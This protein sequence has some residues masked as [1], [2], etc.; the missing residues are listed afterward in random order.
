MAVEG[1]EDAGVGWDW[2]VSGDGRAGVMLGEDEDGAGL[3]MIG[4]EVLRREVLWVG[5]IGAIGDFADTAAFPRM[6]CLIVSDGL[7]DVRGFSVI[8]KVGS[9]RW[10]PNTSFKETVGPLDAI[11]HGDAGVARSS[12]GW[13]DLISEVGRGL[14]LTTCCCCDCFLRSL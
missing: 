1:L 7:E 12:G 14:F 9:G 6:V 3:V 2:R 5:G 4:V 11:C 10:P 8:G 13:A